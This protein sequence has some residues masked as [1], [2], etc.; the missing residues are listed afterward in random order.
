ELLDAARKE[1]P[2]N[3]G[4]KRQLADV[5]CQLGECY[6]RLGLLPE[7]AAVMRVDDWPETTNLWLQV[8]AGQLR[9]LAGDPSSLRKVADRVLISH[10]TDSGAPDGP[11]SKAWTLAAVAL[12][13]ALAPAPTDDADRLLEWARKAADNASATSMPHGVA[14]AWGY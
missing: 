5:E 4:L 1:D 8:R 11:H 6:A 2:K 9:L 12:A 14:R 3:A 10:G 13:H 7:A